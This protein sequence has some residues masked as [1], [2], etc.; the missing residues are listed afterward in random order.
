ME[1]NV[2]NNSDYCTIRVRPGQRQRLK[3]L[4][5]KQDVTMVEL[6]ERLIAQAEAQ[7]K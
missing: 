2:N 4:A 7:E 6:L 1:R 3:V 5:A